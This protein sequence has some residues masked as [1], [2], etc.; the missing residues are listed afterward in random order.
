MN[1]IICEICGTAY[2]DTA[3]K[4]PICGYS[5]DLSAKAA[6]EEF[7]M[8]DAA[9]GAEPKANS[10]S[11]ENKS[12]GIFDFD[13]VNSEIYQD[14]EDE[15]EYDCPEVD[16]EDYEPPRKS[17]NFLIVLLIVAIVAMIGLIGLLFFRYFLP[18]RLLSS[19]E[20]TTVATEVTEE[21]ELTETTIPTV[22][23]TSLVM[24][25]GKAV[26][27]KPGQYWLIHA[28]VLP[29]DT[30]DVLGYTSAD[31]SIATVNEE[32]RVT[33]VSEGKTEIIL[34]CGSQTLNCPVE[35]SFVEETTAPTEAETEPAETEAATE[36]GTEPETTAPAT[37]PAADV[38]LKLKK[39]DI[40]FGARG[41]TFTL[42]LDCDLTPEQVTWTSNNNNVAQVK[43][44]VVT[45][46]GP[47]IT[48]IN[49]EYNGQKVSCVVRCKF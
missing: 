37:K 3:D 6:Q 8:D 26:L 17:H 12:R 41:V 46:I 14:T 15:E 5:R 28:T 40:S 48:N 24:T 4:C 31:E 25:S 30:T 2:P 32:G 16:F 20:P 11:G 13:A 22:P 7:T 29:E 42:E 36:A 18:N 10:D 19:P 43:N 45:T 38:V 49:A 1:K 21:T 27:S 9:P 44:G 35:V 39:T 34:T 47:G 33:A 23:C